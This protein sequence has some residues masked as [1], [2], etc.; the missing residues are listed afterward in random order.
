[1]SDP[2]RIAMRRT[3]GLAVILLATVCLVV[4]ADA[5]SAGFTNWDDPILIMR[6][7]TI[8]TFTPRSVLGVFTRPI[9]GAYL[10]LRTISYAVDYRLWGL[11][12]VGYH[13]TNVLLH[14]ANSVLAFVIARRLLGSTGGAL[15][16]AL[17][18]AVHPAQ[19]ESVVWASGRKEVLSGIF[20][21]AAFW[22]YMGAV[23]PNGKG[24]FGLYLFCLLA[25]ICASLSKPTAAIAPALFVA[26][27]CL[28]PTSVRNMRF[29]GRAVHYAPFVLAAGALIFV[30]LAIGISAE[31]VK[32]GRAASL[33]EKVLNTCA[34]WLEYWRLK[35]L[36]IG[37]CARR[38][39][40]P[41]SGV[42]AIVSVF[43][44]VVWALALFGLR[45]RQAAC[46]ALC[47][48]MIALLPALNLIPVSAAV[49][50]RYMYVPLFGFSVLAAWPVGGRRKFSAVWLLSGVLG[51]WALGGIQQHMT[52]RAN[53]TLWTTSVRRCPRSPEAL[54]NLA[55]TERSASRAN[56]WRRW[57]EAKLRKRVA[58]N[59]AD[60]DAWAD[61]GRV[62]GQ[63]RKIMEASRAFSRA[64]EIDPQFASAH[65]NLA[66]LYAKM[67]PPRISEALRHCGMAQRYG[68]SVPR[69]FVVYLHRARRRTNAK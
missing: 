32:H 50:E 64:V 58:R 9:R 33:G 10:P 28:F 5:F 23:R 49:A 6:N 41:A 66:V 16:A 54:V 1:M 56:V 43:A 48:A 67:V 12:P 62:L 34:I 19:T 37:L 59:P 21:L 29:R 47:W 8:R 11:R 3:G 30:H 22:A 2:H 42:R 55:S 26:Y 61:L 20:L 15:M 53:R 31:V 24:R 45:R 63:Q 25:M 65:Y 51:L 46:F 4:Y 27:D 69:G 14:W 68:Y 38:A 57:A 13:T 60:A 36:P 40:R 7:P 44:V 17:I 52:W 18:F 35:V 39:F